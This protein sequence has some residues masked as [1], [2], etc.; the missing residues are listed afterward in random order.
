MSGRAACAHTGAVLPWEP[1]I[2]LIR[3]SLFEYGTITTE[4]VTAA[5]DNES[6]SCHSIQY[7]AS[8]QLCCLYTPTR[9]AQRE[10]ATVRMQVVCWAVRWLRTLQTHQTQA[11]GANHMQP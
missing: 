8:L 7:C 1:L 9:A 3:G 2:P 10:M 11:S 6:H 5:V 4:I